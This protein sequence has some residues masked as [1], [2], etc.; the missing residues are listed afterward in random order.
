[1]RQYDYIIIWAW[2]YWLHTARYLWN[3]WYKVCLLEKEWDAFTKA[4]FINQARVHNWYHY[5]R[6][7][8]TAIKTKEFFNRFCNDFWFAINK[9]F[10]KIYAIAKEW[11]KTNSVEF[12]SFCHKVGIP[13]KE[14]DKNL[15]FKAWIEKAYETLEYS[16]DAIKIRDFMKSEVEKRTNIDCFYYFNVNE[17]IK[18]KDSIIIKDNNNNKQFK[19]K[20]II[21][22]TYAWINE[23]HELFWV[24]PIKIKYEYT[25]VVLCDV[26][27]EIQNYWLTIMDWEFCSMM[28]FGI[29]N[30]FSITSVKYT[31]HEECYEVKPTFKCDSNEYWIAKSNFNKMY[32]QIKSYIN[33]NIKIKYDKSFFTTKVVLVS[34]EKDDARPTL[35][36]KYN[37]WDGN[38]L[39]TL[40][41]WKINTIYEIED[42]LENIN[43]I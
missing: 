18:G 35:I 7:F 6:S 10:K 22:A 30:K 2:F 3:K 13:C 25:E 37:L 28:P 16:F 36:K 41:S 14:V 24:E 34:T 40:F 9:N 26:N 32:K 19:S 8:N 4:S 39:I 1:M 12:E 20:N 21:N 31:P 11:S 23:I 17:I 38:N 5:P 29:W 42:Y 15:F 27:K 43:K 33:N